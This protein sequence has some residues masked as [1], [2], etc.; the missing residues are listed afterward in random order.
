M[1]F[2]PRTGTLSI[3]CHLMLLFLEGM[4]G[5]RGAWGNVCMDLVWPSSILATFPSSRSVQY[6]MSSATKLI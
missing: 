1:C 5:W 4:D 2:V 3:L 6:R